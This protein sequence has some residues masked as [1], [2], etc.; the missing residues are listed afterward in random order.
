MGTIVSYWIARDPEPRHD[1]RDAAISACGWRNGHMALLS[2]LLLL[3]LALGFGG[4]MVISR[5]N[6]PMLAQ[7]LILIMLID[8]LVQYMVRLRLYW[9]ETQAE[10]SSE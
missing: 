10:R 1:E 3:A 2:M 8:C 6:Q 7:L 9:L 4:R 5:F